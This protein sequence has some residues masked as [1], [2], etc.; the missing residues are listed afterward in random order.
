M[1][2]CSEE[3]VEAS[4]PSY[5]S[6]HLKAA[7]RWC[8]SGWLVSSTGAAATHTS[9]QTLAD[10]HALLACLAACAPAARAPPPRPAGAAAPAGCAGDGAAG[11][12]DGTDLVVNA[13]PEEGRSRDE[14]GLQP[15][16]YTQVN[17]L[18]ELVLHYHYK[19]W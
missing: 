12:S 8:S 19:Y 13:R 11:W 5:T 9:S 2:E 7:R 14:E 10:A 15:H 6:E 16:N 1:S 4:R 3:D 17:K 18:N